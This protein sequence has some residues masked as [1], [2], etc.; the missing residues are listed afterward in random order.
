MYLLNPL[1]GYIS[2]ADQQYEN[3]VYDYH[4]VKKMNSV[5]KKF[6]IADINKNGSRE[7]IQGDGLLKQ[8][9]HRVEGLAVRAVR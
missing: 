4:L 6:V 8:V 3:N 7:Q 2:V 1:H 5:L 9:L